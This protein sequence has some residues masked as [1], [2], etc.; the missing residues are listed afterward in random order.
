MKNFNFPTKKN[1][2]I[3]F[4]KNNFNLNEFSKISDCESF[5]DMHINYLYRPGLGRWIGYCN[6]ISEQM[7]ENRKWINDFINDYS[8]NLSV[9]LIIWSLSNGFTKDELVDIINR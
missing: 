9:M 3:E 5:K 6:I 8:N 7:N 4:V 2:I 1:E